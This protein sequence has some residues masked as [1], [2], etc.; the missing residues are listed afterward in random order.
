MAAASYTTDL[1]DILYAH[2][3]NGTQPDPAGISYSKFTNYSVGKVPSFEEDYY[4]Q[5]YGCYSQAPGNGI[6]LTNVGAVDSVSQATVP[7]DGAVLLWIWFGAPNALATKAGGGLRALLGDNSSNFYEYY[8]NGSDTYTYGG[9]RCYAIDPRVTPQGTVGTPTLP[10]G[11]VAA[12]GTGANLINNVFKG[13]PLAL[14]AVRYGRCTLTVTDGDLANGYATFIDAAAFNDYNDP[15]NGYNRMGLLQ[16][17]DGSFTQQGLFQMGTGATPVDFRDLNRNIVI[18]NTEFVSSAFNRFEINNAGSNV[19]WTGISI[20]S[21][22][23]NSPGTLV[24][25]DGATVSISSCAFSNMGSFGF[26]PNTTVTGTTFNQCDLITQNGATITGCT[27]ADTKA[28][29]AIVDPDFSTFTG[30]TFSSGTD[31]H[32]I[33]ITQPGSYVF[34]NIKFLNYGADETTNAAIYNNS[35]GAVTVTVTGGG[36]VPTVRNAPGST[37]TIV[38]GALVTLTGLKADSE[39]RAYLGTNPATATELAGT[40][41]SGTTFQFAHNVAGQDGFIT[42]F[43]LNYQ[44]IYLTLTYAGVDSS[45]P[46]QQIID[47]Q[48]I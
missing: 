2:G 46:I 7:V 25:N 15:T 14:D 36:T 27:I 5:G 32:G 18:Q 6:G 22:G 30:I 13:N 9:W 17:S 28:T 23:T 11:T 12:Y 4:V 1:T 21:L 41:S 37:T 33:E 10:S 31:F 45:Y 26:G 35:G 20:T 40:E 48:Y 3:T 39:V 29:S 8:I 38:S 42:I 47:R 34:S 44:A 43:H 24:V 16:Y 19:E